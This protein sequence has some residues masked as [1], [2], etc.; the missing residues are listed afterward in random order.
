MKA[1][2]LIMIPPNGRCKPDTRLC[3]SMSDYHQ[4]TWNPN[5]NIRTIMI[6]FYSFMLEESST[7]GSIENN[8]ITSQELAK[9]SS[10]FNK[11]INSFNKIFDN[12]NLDFN[13]ENNKI[14]NE[15]NMC[16][17]CYES[18]GELVNVCNCKGS[19]GYVH[20]KCLN[21]WQLKTILNQSTHPEQQVNSDIICSI[22][23]SEYKIK[24]K[25]RH[26]IMTELTGETILNQIKIGFIFLSSIESSKKNI[27]LIEKYRSLLFYEN[28]M[29]WTYGVF[30]IIE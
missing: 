29:H 25:S 20:I 13:N 8:F 18:E 16:K 24:N 5:W 27:D 3:F 17:F 12:I 26:E 14:S 19:L 15:K 1:P 7:E 23:K 22:C 4:E 6:G 11:S 21:E 10:I 28:I 2:Q 30:L 9:N